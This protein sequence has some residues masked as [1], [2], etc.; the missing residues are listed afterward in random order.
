VKTVVL[1][2]Y[3]NFG[4]LIARALSSEPS[5]EP[6]IAGRDEAKARAMAA[7]LGAGF[8]RLDADDPQLGNRLADLGA[9]L[10]ISTAGPFQGQDYRVARAAIAA[11][12]HYVDI[13]DGREFVCGIDGLDDEARAAGVLVTSG[14][15]SV[16]ALS[17][18]VVDRYAR[19]FSALETIDIGICT[20]SRIPG[21]ATVKAVL[22]YSG[23]PIP[24]LR[25]GWQ[26]L[27]RHRFRQAPFARWIC[28]C[29]VPD[30]Q[31]LPIRH[32]GL[33]SLRFGAG[34]QPTFV[35]WG[36]WALA[37]AV[38]AG[39]GWSRAR[40][41]ESVAACSRRVEALGSSRCAMFVRLSGRD[42][43]RHARAITWELVAEN[44]EGAN[45]PCMGA[46][47]L[48]RKLASGGLETGAR[49][50]VGLID[51]DEYLAELRPYRVSWGAFEG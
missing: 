48:A 33:L 32:P 14:A 23:K 2:G 44:H 42:A 26:G 1:G 16:P 41:A 15:S 28:D 39:L 17:S 30:L 9:K 13:A 38:R 34:L 4:R 36:L 24:G 21:I 29:D 50:C 22:G 45:I 25:H 37:G 19:E 10:V 31:L 7:Q 6:L 51:H 46:V 12:A 20:S 47:S 3:G 11:G 35:H 27:R 8:A 49:P 40:G 18:A 43:N 5:I